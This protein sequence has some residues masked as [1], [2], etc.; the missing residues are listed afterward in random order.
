MRN[1]SGSWIRKLSVGA[2]IADLLEWNYIGILKLN[3]HLI[4]IPEKNARRV[5]EKREAEGFRPRR[6]SVR[7]TRKYFVS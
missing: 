4:L 7:I 6:K 1:A 2:V 3:S 5:S